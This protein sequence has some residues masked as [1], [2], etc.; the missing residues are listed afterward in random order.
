M[1]SVARDAGTLDQPGV[2]EL[3]GEARVLELAD[4]K[5]QERIAVAVRS[6]R[7]PDQ[8]AA[9]GRLFHGV[10][11][12][13]IR[14]IT[15]EVAGSAG[16]AWADSDGTA[17]GSGIEFLMRQASCIGGGTTEMAR[18]VIS[19][20]LLGMP[21]ERTPDRDTAFRDVPRSSTN[22]TSKESL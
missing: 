4:A 22:H 10:A 11:S 18:N 5:V 19:E 16:A 8:A 13:R 9:V 21:R 7:M 6:G 20:R 15:L 2:R 17:A 1:V 12:A 14:T 3:V